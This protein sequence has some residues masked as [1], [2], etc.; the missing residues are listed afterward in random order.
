[1]VHYDPDAAVAAKGPPALCPKCGS[2]R[3]EVVGLDGPVVTIRCN[4]CGERSQIDTRTMG[5]TMDAH[6][7]MTAT[8]DQDL[9]SEVEVMLQVAHALA[10]LPDLEAR[11]RVLRWTMER[12]HADLPAPAGETAV[13]SLR[14]AADPCLAVDGLA[15][16]FP[17]RLATDDQD[18]EVAP[19]TEQAATPA[20]T[21]QGIETLVRGFAADFRRFALEWQGA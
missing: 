5:R 4:A 2:H 21:Q 20:T 16:F 7:D 10:T 17:V 9:V 14:P 15:D 3:T 13:A 1:M 19:E 12:F 6:E 11:R 18:L 8:G